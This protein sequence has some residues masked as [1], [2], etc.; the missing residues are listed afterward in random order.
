VRS[1]GFSTR[2]SKK[3]SKGGRPEPTPEEQQ[4]YQDLC[5]VQRRYAAVKEVPIF[6]FDVDTTKFHLPDERGGLRIHA[7]VPRAGAGA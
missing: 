5:D 6:R 3:D 7:Q 4:M 2:G 1:W